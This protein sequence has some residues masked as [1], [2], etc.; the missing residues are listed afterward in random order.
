MVLKALC[1]IDSSWFEQN[2]RPIVIVSPKQNAVTP[3]I[4]QHL[5]EQQN[6]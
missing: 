5:K 4:T 2:C 1:P 3:S 6:V